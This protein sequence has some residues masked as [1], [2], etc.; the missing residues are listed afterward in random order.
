MLGEE[1][2]IWTDWPDKREMDQFPN[3]C[4]NQRTAQV[5]SVYSLCFCYVNAFVCEL[6]FRSLCSPTASVTT[7]IALY[8]DYGNIPSLG[9]LDGIV[10]II[11]RNIKLVDC[12][13]FHYYT[14]SIDKHEHAFTCRLIL[15]GIEYF[16]LQYRFDEIRSV[17]TNSSVH[18]YTNERVFK[19]TMYS[20]ITFLLSRNCESDPD[21]ERRKWHAVRVLEPRILWPSDGV[22]LHP[23]HSLVNV[24]M[25]LL[26]C[27]MQNL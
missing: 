5:R 9:M 17:A 16:R 13:A 11:H 7:T 27:E 23:F 26:Q 8:S 19:C 25:Y 1:C 3:Q 24:E 22:G 12:F 4:V 14:S 21:H 18:T 2:H 10:D 20:F 6:A 15:R